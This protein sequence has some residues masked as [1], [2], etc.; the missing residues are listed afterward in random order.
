M[1]SPNPQIQLLFLTPERLTY[2]DSQSESKAQIGDSDIENALLRRLKELSEQ[3]KV[4]R[5]VIDEA[6]CV[7][8]WGHDFRP[9]YAVCHCFFSILLLEEISA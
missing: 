4:A 1:L 9:Q 2:C 5:F 8:Q 3:N 7:T 6:H